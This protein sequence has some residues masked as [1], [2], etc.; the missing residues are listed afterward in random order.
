[1][2]RDIEQSIQEAEDAI[3]N[4]DEIVE[5]RLTEAEQKMKK[6]IVKGVIWIFI[7]IAIYFIWGI[8]W[9]FWLS[10]SLNILTVL[11]VIFGKVM[12][13]KARRKML[14]DDEKNENYGLI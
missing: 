8:T 9:F 1:M 10:F 13:A 2:S 4:L 3:A 5:N 11:G 7:T 6:G 12:I 14:K